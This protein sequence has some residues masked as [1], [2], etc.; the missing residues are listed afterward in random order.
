MEGVPRP[1]AKE[2][3]KRLKP[4]PHRSCVGHRMEGF[5]FMDSAMLLITALLSQ[6]GSLKLRPET[7]STI[8][9]CASMPLCVCTPT[10][11]CPHSQAPIDVHVSELAAVYAVRF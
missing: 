7:G 6:R 2:T 9:L 4:Q 1:Q 8:P 5:V 10:H 3:Q 11:A